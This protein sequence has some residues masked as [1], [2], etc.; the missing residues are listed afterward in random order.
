MPKNRIELTAIA[1]EVLSNYS[2]KVAELDQQENIAHRA[3]VMVGLKR[4][5]RMRIDKL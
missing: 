1:V 2:Q 3:D 5:A 4:R